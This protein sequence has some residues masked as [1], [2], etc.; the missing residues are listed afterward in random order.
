MTYLKYRSRIGASTI[1]ISSRI[2][3]HTI[4]FADDNNFV[5]GR[6]INKALEVFVHELQTGHNVGNEKYWLVESGSTFVGYQEDHRGSVPKM[7]RVR[8]DLIEYLKQNTYQVN[9]AI[10]LACDRWRDYFKKNEVAVYVITE[11]TDK[12]KAEQ[13]QGKKKATKDTAKKWTQCGNCHYWQPKNRQTDG[14]APC[15]H[16]TKGGETYR[17]AFCDHFALNLENV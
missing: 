1:L 16:P 11:L 9:T 14:K 4:E 7:I 15:N 12:K 2:Q 13:K 17:A 8:A 3:R 10:N 6:F 5:F